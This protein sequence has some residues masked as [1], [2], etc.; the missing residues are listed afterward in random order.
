M[1][2]PCVPSLHPSSLDQLLCPAKFIQDLSEFSSDKLSS[3]LALL[4]TL[5]QSSVLLPAWLGDLGKNLQEQFS[6]GVLQASLIPG[7]VTSVSSGIPGGREGGCG[8]V[9][10]EGGTEMLQ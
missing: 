3:T 8:C 2:L 4:G 6:L 7:T 5:T 9:Q 10:P 1:E